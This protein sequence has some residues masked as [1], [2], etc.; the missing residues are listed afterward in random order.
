MDGLSN[1]ICCDSVYLYGMQF[2]RWPK[3]IVRLNHKSRSISWHIKIHFHIRRHIRIAIAFL[4]VP[5]MPSSHLI[6][7]GFVIAERVL[8]VPS[9]GYCLLVAF[10]MQSIMPNRAKIIRVSYVMLLA[11]FIMRCNQRA[12]DW[13]N[14]SNLFTSAIRVCPNNAKIYYNLG[15]IHASNGDYHKSLAFNQRANHLNPNNV[16]ILTNLGTSNQQNSLH[17]FRYK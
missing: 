8:Y 7:V 13:Q 3:V 11:I 16:G 1:S 17:T 2:C 14:N 4:I 5:F 9:L 6:S 10:G 15:Q 12:I